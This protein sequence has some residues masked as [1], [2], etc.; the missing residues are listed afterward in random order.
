[1]WLNVRFPNDGMLYKLTV[2]NACASRMTHAKYLSLS[3]PNLS[4]YS[5]KQQTCF[6]ITREFEMIICASDIA[7][8]GKYML[9]SGCVAIC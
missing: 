1:M 8:L 6:R 7:H 5:P 2:D 9:S 4:P 3:V